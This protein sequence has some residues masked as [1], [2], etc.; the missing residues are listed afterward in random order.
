M[1]C[2]VRYASKYKYGSEGAVWQ[3]YPGAFAVEEL[4]EHG[5]SH[6]WSVY[7][8]ARAYEAV[9]ETLM[10]SPYLRERRA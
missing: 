7:L 8:T 10:F 6:G 4:T 1:A 9:R 5:W 2:E 3:A